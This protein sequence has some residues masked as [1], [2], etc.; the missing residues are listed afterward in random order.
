MKTIMFGAIM[1]LVS[2]VSFAEQSE[3]KMISQIAVMDDVLVEYMGQ[4]DGSDLYE[5][6]ATVFLGSNPCIAESNTVELVVERVETVTEVFALLQSPAEPRICTFEYRPV[7]KT[8]SV[9][10]DIDSRSKDILLR[11]VVLNDEVTTVSYREFLPLPAPTIPCHEEGTLYAGGNPLFNELTGEF[12]TE[13]EY[14]ASIGLDANCNVI[15]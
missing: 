14:L 2:Q 3:P 10:V 6:N 7:Y 1:A 5:I 13:E 11:D 12:M 9:L 15:K 4:E 8:L